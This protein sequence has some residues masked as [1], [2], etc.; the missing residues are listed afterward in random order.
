MCVCVSKILVLEGIGQ[1]QG[2]GMARVR[3]GFWVRV[4]VWGGG[5]HTIARQPP[6]GV[7]FASH[8]DLTF[9]GSFCSVEPEPPKKEWRKRP[10]ERSDRRRRS[11]KTDRLRACIR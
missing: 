4:G 1:G 5:C 7:G 9:M 8:Y 11:P 6:R 10:R 2:Q 3:V